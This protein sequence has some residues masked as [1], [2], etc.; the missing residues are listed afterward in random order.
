ME[1]IR[2]LNEKLAFADRTEAC[3]SISA[4]EKFLKKSL[5]NT[6]ILEEGKKVYFLNLQTK[7]ICT[8]ALIMEV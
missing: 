6:M 8:L 3:E 7:N 4:A 1:Q 2:D 5:I